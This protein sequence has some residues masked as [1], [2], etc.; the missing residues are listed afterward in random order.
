MK[1]TLFQKTKTIPGVPKYGYETKMQHIQSLGHT[2]V[3]WER[4][5]IVFTCKDCEQER[6]TEVK[7]VTDS[8]TSCKVC[9]MKQIGSNIA[10]IKTGMIYKKSNIS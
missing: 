7:R 10:K 1:P 9:K 5:E 4:P 8:W 3:R 2:N 6:R